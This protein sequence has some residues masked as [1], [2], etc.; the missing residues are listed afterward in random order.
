MKNRI[1]ILMILL[2]LLS[3]SACAKNEEVYERTEFMMDTVINLKIYDGKN[4]EAMEKGIKELEN[5]E[6]IMSGHID[7]SDVSKINKNAGI[8]AVEVD[9]NLYNIIKNA[10]HIAEISGGGYDPTIGPLVELWD[11]NEGKNNRDSLPEK[12]DIEKAREL[13]DYK[14]L[15][16][17]DGNRIYLENKGMKIDLGGIVKGYAADRVKEIFEDN[18]VKS[19]IID[20][21]GNIFTLGTRPDGG[22]WKIGIQNPIFQDRGYLGI[23]G[24]ENKTIV[25]SG[26]YE[27]YFEL[28]GKRY[29]HIIDQDTGYPSDSDL[30]SVSIISN[31]SEEADALSTAV[32]VL[33]Y[34]KG[35]ALID[36]LEDVEAIYV[37]KNKNVIVDDKLRQD[38]ELTEKEFILK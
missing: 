25:T 36:E 15:Q 10:K 24:L 30:S 20:L 3:L 1:K 8:E 35:K 31:N 28:D 2:S 38:F 29:H 33:G 6:K 32:F 14:K 22:K 4:D 11:I 12:E 18:G 17:L 13:V 5:I 23:L 34:E 26:A 7:T 19:A 21:G 16:I 37:L 9:E 27:R